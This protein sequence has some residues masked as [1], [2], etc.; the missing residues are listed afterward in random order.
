LQI[1]PV[2]DMWGL[3][4]LLADG[5]VGTT[6]EIYDVVL[7]GVLDD[8][9]AVRGAGWPSSAR[10]AVAALAG[11]A[12]VPLTAGVVA[13]IATSLHWT[14]RSKTYLDWPVQVKPASVTTTWR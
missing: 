12:A 13:V 14:V 7:R 6:D 11:A 1:G 2:D 10:V 8:I 5:A 9:L 3:P 4:V